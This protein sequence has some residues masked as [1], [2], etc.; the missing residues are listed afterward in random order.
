MTD[1]KYILKGKEV[2]EASLEEWGKFLSKPEKIVKQETLPNGLRVS[3][4][5]LGMDYNCGEGEPLLFETM[6]FPPDSYSDKH[7]QRYSTYEEAEKGH[8]EMVKKWAYIG[9]L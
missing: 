5:F 3:T 8:Q 1:K 6:V 9:T 4:V 2:V 7:C